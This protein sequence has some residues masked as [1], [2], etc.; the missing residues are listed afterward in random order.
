MRPLALVA[1]AAAVAG[2]GACGGDSTLTVENRSSYA[3]VEINLSPEDSA[4][5]GPD[6]LDVDILYP[7]ESAEITGID[8]DTYDVRIVDE[9]LDE[10]VLAG[11]ELCLDD[12]V[13][14]ITDEE[15]ALW[16]AFSS[17]GAAP[18][19]E[20]R[21]RPPAREH[22]DHAGLRATTTLTTART[23][24][25]HYRRGATEREKVRVPWSG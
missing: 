6:L 8:C 21:S 15:L 10:C 22:R 25:T 12:A 17:I 1:A 14:T 11:V 18:A 3:I 13:W 20:R 2:L 23:G 24:T 7:G 4:S 19:P 16:A 5:W 9:D